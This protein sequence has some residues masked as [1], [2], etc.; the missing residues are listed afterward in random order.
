MKRTKFV[1]ISATGNYLATASD[2]YR[3]REKKHPGSMELI[4]ATGKDIRE[5]TIH[6]FIEEHLKGANYLFIVFHGGRTSIPL[7]DTLIEQ[8]GNTHVYIHPSEGEDLE[9]SQK[10]ST[11][12]ENGFFKHILEYITYDGVENWESL[13]S[14]ACE[15]AEKGSFDAPKLVRLPTEGIYH[16][17][18]G[19]VFSLEDYF[20][21][22][23]VKADK[24]IQKGTPVIGISFFRG[25]YIEGNV[26]HIDALIEEIE[27]QGAFPV[28][29]FSIRFPDTRVNNLTTREVFAAY[30]S[31]HGKTF[32]HVLLNLHGFSIRQTT[33]MDAAVYEALDV[34]VLQT[35]TLY[36]PYE[37]WSTTEQGVS[38]MDVTISAAQ[39]EFDGALITLPAATYEK[40]GPD[41]DTGATVKV[42]EPIPERIEKLISLARNWAYLGTKKNSEKRVAIIF[43][44]YP[45]RNDRI[46]TAAGLDS[47]E[48][49]ASILGRLKTEGYRLEQV[50]ENGKEL[51]EVV[52]SGLTND[53][54]WLSCEAMAGRSCDTIPGEV[55]SEW[56]ESFPEKVKEHM[57]RD[58]G[59]PPGEAFVYQNEVI[60]GGI[61]N[62]NLFIGIQPP[63]GYLDQPDKIHDPHLPPTYH[64]LYF[65]WWVRWVFKADAVVHVGKHGSLE[66]LPGKTM[67]LSR[68]CYPDLA[69]QD[70][71]NIYPYIINDPSEGT[72]AKRRSYAV[73]DDHMIPVMTNADKYEEL[74]EVDTKLLE[75]LQLSIS[76]PDRTE[77]LKRDIWETAK[78]HNLSSDVEISEAEAF[79]D[80][81]SF[82]HDL[83][84][85]ISEVSDT[86]INKGLHILGHKPEGEGLG[87]LCNQLVRLKNGEVPSL[88]ESVARS[89]GYD[90]GKLLNDRGGKDETG[91]FTTHAQ[92]LEAIRGECLRIA[93][94]MVGEG[95]G[96]EGREARR[97]EGEIPGLE[98][99]REYMEEVLLPNIRRIEDE[100]E[101]IIR[102]LSGKHIAPGASGSPTRGMADILP[103]GRNFFSVD[104]FKIPGESAWKAGIALG[105]AL[106]EAYEKDNGKPPD[107]VAMVVWAG[108][109]MRTLGEDV[110]EALYLMGIKP[111]WNR[112][113]G[114]I[115]GLEI[116]PTEELKYP[117]VDITFRTSGLFRD[118]FPNVMELLD[119]AVM[120]AAALDEPTAMNSIRKNVQREKE[121]L[122]LRGMDPDKAEREASF[123]V[124][125]D[126]PGGY[127]TGVPEMI[128]SKQWK[129]AD[130]LGNM[131][132]H[133]GGY[134]YGK[135]VYGSDQRET[136]AR[137]LSDINLVVKNEDSREYD[138]L[139][140]TD[141]NAYHGGLVA[142]V[143]A[144]S[145]SYPQA[146]S[147]DA[148]DPDRMKYRTIQ[149]ESKHV[150]RSRVLNPKWIEGLKDHGFKGAGDMS[151]AIDTAFHW[152]ATSEVVEDWMYDGIAH[153]YAFDD[154]MK[155]WFQEVNPYALQNILEKLLEAIA[156]GMWEASEE[157]KRRLDQMYMEIE[158][159]IEDV[160]E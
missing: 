37:F 67:A 9:L 76:D 11:G 80:F 49:V 33:P 95:S 24:L 38:P 40:S 157:T 66:W 126:P 138:M 10:Y 19:V 47:F 87:E 2:A 102:A 130:D 54:R 81:D 82:A 6:Q 60:I 86:A 92:A 28:P 133:W 65:Y 77:R 144:S 113:N 32:I 20:E 39:P 3:N 44:N 148:S 4:C 17:Q 93:A 123:R 73:I 125:S 134:A 156:R 100:E 131:F 127:G 116:L 72:Q 120:M 51:A 118:T 114:R 16:P 121:E 129:D 7:F 53:K 135:E 143:K 31:R 117:R 151:H 145:G 58:L 50:Y 83:H 48:S 128:E 104:P 142:A 43:H 107:T 154:S 85:Y 149:Q 70:L 112:R 62:G 79:K 96:R 18:F 63:R 106:V 21:K 97:K 146:Y 45:P 26:K 46:G 139:S 115:D 124:F 78:K 8:T 159:D 158:G 57:E 29:C 75:Y 150:F 105:E 13:F 99:I 30:F 147:G 74:A 88:P 34:P 155:K 132:I 140:C 89:W 119:E 22:A 110:A 64:Y 136:F 94:E 90:Y 42:C 141:F 59:K 111:V 25:N 152:D 137:R 91:K 12:Y 69:I 14:I 103:T 101:T 41:P 56:T 36:T 61:R 84:S 98:T 122:I 109:T 1:L 52:L 160:L 15:L 153:R 108:N 35:I 68:D 27:K 23:G 5:E 71:P 55:Y